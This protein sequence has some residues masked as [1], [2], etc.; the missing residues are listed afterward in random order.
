M[1]APGNDYTTLSAAIVPVEAERADVLVIGGGS[2]G[3][4]AAIAAREAGAEVLVLERGSGLSGTT[5]LAGGMLYLGG[6]TPVQKANG[7]DD[8]PQA[9]FDYLMANTPEPDE[10]KLRLY[11]DESVDHFA[12]LQAQDVPFTEGYYA[13]KHHTPPGTNCLSWSGNEK[14]W[15]ISE[16]A[17]PAPRG[18]KVAHDT[19]GG[20]LLIQRLG[21]TAER[22]GVRFLYDANVTNLVTDE[23]GAVVGARFTVFG[24]ER[25]A[26]A[27]RG[28]ALAAGAFSMNKEMVNELCPTL[29]RYGIHRQGNPND[30]GAGIRMGVEAGGRAVHMEKAFVTA[31]FYPP[32]SLIKAIFVNKHGERFINEDCY[33]ARTMD[34]AVGQP[35]GVVYLV[36]DETTFGRPEL[37]MQPL[38]DAWETIEEMERDLGLPEGKLQATIERYNGFAETGEDLDFHK[39]ADWLAPIAT[40]PFAALQCSVGESYYV[41]FTLGGLDVSIDAEVLGEDGAPIPG[42]YAAGACA[43]NIAQDGAG[44]SSGTCIGEATFFGRRGGRHAAGR[45]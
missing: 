12:W 45:G 44:Y 36:C 31:P 25:F 41:G 38:I 28:V 3:L 4:S 2:A 42:L 13:P 43:S 6:G 8:T 22:L 32:E 26:R 29:A 23:E 37:E 35:D 10:E 39:H 34:A 19:E 9:M 1:S 7:F 17:A 20:A 15:P 24:E 33:H 5:T 16:N 14:A 21:A 40:P 30:D 11:C 27:A 18:H